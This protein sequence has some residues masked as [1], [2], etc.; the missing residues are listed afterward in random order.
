MHNSLILSLCSQIFAYGHAN[1][2]SEQN[3]CHTEKLVTLMFFVWAFACITKA[4]VQN[5]NSLVMKLIFS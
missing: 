3:L 1:N 4:Y 5:S 2:G